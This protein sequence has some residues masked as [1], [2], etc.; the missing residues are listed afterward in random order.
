MQNIDSRQF[1]E[2]L[3]KERDSLEIIDVREKDEAD[4]V[5]VKGSK[6][7]PMNELQGRL[8]E[9][10]WNKKVV[11]LCRSGARSEY[12]ADI[13]ER[14]TQKNIINLAGGI[15]QLNLDDCDCLEKTEECCEGYF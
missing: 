6:L 7:I 10:D 4:L 2:M 14:Q 1:K 8:N 15:Y 9:I 13:I 12:M 11:F 3:D 5:R